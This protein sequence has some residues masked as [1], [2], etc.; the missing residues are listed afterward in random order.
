[1]QVEIK[2]D[3]SC[4]EPRVVIITDMVSREPEQKQYSKKFEIGNIQFTKCSYK[5]K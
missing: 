3:D 4:I 1:M 5:I 2:I